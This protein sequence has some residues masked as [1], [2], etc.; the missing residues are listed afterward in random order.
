M[1]PIPPAAER[2]IRREA[3]SATLRERALA[4]RRAAD[5]I[6]GIEYGRCKAKIMLRR[7]GSVWINS[8][9]HG[10]M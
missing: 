1:Q 4:L 3:R 7:N 9:A 2:C 8:F 5:P 10:G 6:E